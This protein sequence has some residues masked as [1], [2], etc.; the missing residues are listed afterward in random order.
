[1]KQTRTG[2][3]DSHLPIPSPHFGCFR[4]QAWHVFCSLI[5]ACGSSQ[6]WTC[7]LIWHTGHQ[8]RGFFC[9]AFHLHGCAHMSGFDKHLVAPGRGFGRWPCRALITSAIG[10]VSACGPVLRRCHAGY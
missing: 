3:P 4:R 8:I 10:S 2:K 7:P 9:F 6:A 5:S 1:M